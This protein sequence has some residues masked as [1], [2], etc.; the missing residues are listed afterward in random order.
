MVQRGAAVL[1]EQDFEFRG[2][3]LLVAA[4]S[5]AD[6]KALVEF[7]VD[8]SHLWDHV[9]HNHQPTNQPTPTNQPRPGD[10]RTT[11]KFLLQS[12]RR[13][14]CVCVVVKFLLSS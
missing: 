14:R 10:G 6:T 8:M 2:V 12:S 9:A 4:S 11:A 3:L 5:P 7:P 1:L 13:R